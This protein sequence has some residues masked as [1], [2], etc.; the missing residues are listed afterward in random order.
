M[1]FQV[2]LSS[3]SASSYRMPFALEPSG[4]ISLVVLVEK[5]ISVRCG[6]SNSDVSVSL[7]IRVLHVHSS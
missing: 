3:L 5:R 4:A 7:G 1:D 6:V 2:S